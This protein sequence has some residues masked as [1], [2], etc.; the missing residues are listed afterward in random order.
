[1]LGESI[2]GLKTSMGFLD[3]MALVEEGNREMEQ[4]PTIA[5]VFVVTV[6]DFE[7]MRVLG[8]SSPWVHHAVCPTTIRRPSRNEAFPFAH[9]NCET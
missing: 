6:V 4:N 8:F 3:K 9:P 7:T 5:A 2:W 1:M